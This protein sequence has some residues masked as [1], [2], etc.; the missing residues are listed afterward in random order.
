[1]ATK[2][3]WKVECNRCGKKI[4]AADAEVCWYCIKDLC[5]ECWDQHGECGHDAAKAIIEAGEKNP[6]VIRLSQV[7]PSPKNQN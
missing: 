2:N 4:D 5:G 7:I 1:M 3:D 6:G